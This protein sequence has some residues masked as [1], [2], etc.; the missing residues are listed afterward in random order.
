M[1]LSTKEL[2]TL[3]HLLSEDNVNHFSCTLEAVRGA[4]YRNFT[5]QDYFRVG[6]ALTVL[7]QERD[8]LPQPAQRIAAVF[9]LL[10]LYHSGPVSLNP[11][12]TFLA[13]LLKPSIEDERAAVGLPCGH[14]LSPAE[15]YF[16]AELIQ[17][18]APRDILLRKTPSH[19]AA[20]D[21][22]S[23]EVNYRYYLHNQLFCWKYTRLISLLFLGSKN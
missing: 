8:L 13:E 18:S 1:A 12:A 7:L 9:L 11:F 20:T 5:R 6:T 3:L 14:H 17:P 23:L 16:V 19:I 22:A 15:I 21:V 4:F 2:S 10:E